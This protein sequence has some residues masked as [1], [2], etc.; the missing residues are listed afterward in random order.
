MTVSGYVFFWSGLVWSGLRSLT[1]S[2]QPGFVWSGLDWSV[3][4]NRIWSVGF[5][6]VWSGL[7]WSVQS[8]RIWGPLVPNTLE[9]VL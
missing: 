1:V 4:S 8:D 5:R 6:L 2:G 9:Q 7:V 3:Q